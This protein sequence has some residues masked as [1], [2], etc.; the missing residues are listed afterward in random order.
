MAEACPNA[1]FR[2]GP[3]LRLPDCRAYEMVTPP[4]KG[5]AAVLMDRGISLDGE[6]AGLQSLA[7]FAEVGANEG[8]EG[9][10]F[11]ARRAPGG[12]GVTPLNPPASQFEAIMNEKNIFGFDNWG[13]SADQSTELWTLRGASQ[14]NNRVDLFVS[15]S[16]GSVTDVGPVLPPTAA[17]GVPLEMSG[18]V[19]VD[20]LSADGSH[21]VFHTEPG[22]AAWSFAPPGALLEYA[23]T[24]NST[25]TPLGIEDNGHFIDECPT[26]RLAFSTADAASLGITTESLHP[27]SKDGRVVFVTDGCKEEL[28]A[29]VDNGQ[30]DAHTVAISEPS[31]EDCAACDTSVGVRKPAHFLGASEDGSRVFF[32][33]EQP[34]LEGE[35]GVY[36]Y[37]SAGAEGQRVVKVIGSSAGVGASAGTGGVEAISADGSHIYF[38][39]SGALPSVVNY[40]GAAPLAGDN[41]L[42]FYERD[43]QYPTG[44]IGFVAALPHN[45]LTQWAH[46]NA[47]GFG[48]E[49]N[50]TETAHGGQDPQ[51]TP[52]GRF[53]VFLS[54]ADLT[55]DDTSTAGQVFEYDSQAN[56]MSRISIG[57][58]GFNDNGNVELYDPLHVGNPAWEDLY[59][60]DPNDARLAPRGNLTVSSD[61]AEVFFE[62]NAALTPQALNH[63]L[64][65]TKVSEDSAG[66]T[67]SVAFAHNIYEYHAGSVSLISDGHDVAVTTDPLTGLGVI[68][69]GGLVGTD[70]SGRDVFFRTEDS[71]L[72]Q[73]TDTSSDLYDARVDGGFP[74]SSPPEDC[75]ADAC[76]GTLS[77]APVLLSPGSEFQAGEAGAAVAPT[78]QVASSKSKAKK[79][80]VKKKRRTRK[81][82]AKKAARR[83]RGRRGANR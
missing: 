36:L 15:R 24:G 32:R 72:A 27:I 12:W 7:G 49:L 77:A 69:V 18:S 81:G 6:A 80:A 73:D 74:P 54:H 34:L 64:L 17:P 26:Q 78:Q 10:L 43:V 9:A 62:S 76:Q 35:G 70:L 2:T 11:V 29:R 42:Y 25:P 60:E 47:A 40:V 75:A 55:A 3:S 50:G 83:G 39:A 23:G 56:R 33:T 48:A 71:L 5:G 37:D 20:G 68:A 44:R 19:Q 63:A 45:D 46:I 14:A 16:D 67:H 61:G 51:T 4:F 66:V 28:F 58:E 57:R 31:A 13:G 82:K 53:L 30:P 8:F 21:V 38:V 1:A 79:K 22:F 41:N 52:D 65:G 59:F